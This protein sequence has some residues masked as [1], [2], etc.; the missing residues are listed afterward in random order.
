MNDATKK[1]LVQWT[2]GIVIG[3]VILFALQPSDPSATFVCCWMG[4]G[5]VFCLTFATKVA[6]V[7]GS[8]LSFGGLPGYIVGLLVGFMIGLL[9]GPVIGVYRLI[10]A[11]TSGMD[12]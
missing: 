12:P 5:V 3:I 6:N 4:T 7:V 8:I 9:A 2:I 1:V 10:V 11:I